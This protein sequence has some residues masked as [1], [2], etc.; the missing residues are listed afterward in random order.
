MVLDGTKLII[1]SSLL[2]VDEDLTKLN[3]TQ[4]KALDVNC[5]NIGEFYQGQCS[6]QVTK[7][8]SSVHLT[9]S[10]RPRVHK[11]LIKADFFFSTVPVLVLQSWLP[12]CHNR[13]PQHKHV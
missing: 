1:C 2:S 3:L 6:Q 7:L 10:Q 9:F 4:Q 5:P 12:A 8:V 13:V 11:Y